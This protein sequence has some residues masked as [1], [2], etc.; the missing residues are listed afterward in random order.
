MHFIYFS[1]RKVVELLL[2]AGADVNIEAL[3]GFTAF[4]LAM[5]VENT[6]VEL[7]R[8]LAAQSLHIQSQCSSFALRRSRA[9]SDSTLIEEENNQAI[10]AW[11]YKI[12]NR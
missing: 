7:V 4:D 10:K 11:W 6:D 2:E 8:L 5:L 9:A 1:R 3:D 12:S